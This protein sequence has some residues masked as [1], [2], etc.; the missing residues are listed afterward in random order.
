M[1]E[2][3]GKMAIQEGA[4]YLER[5]MGGKGILLGGVPGVRPARVAILGGGVVGT[6]AAKAAAGLGARVTV[7]DKNA[8]R[9]RYL[10][11]ILPENVDTVSANRRSVREACQEAD[12]LVGAVYSEGAKASR[13]VSEETVKSMRPGSV[14]VDVSIDQGGCV[15]TSHPT[16]HS[17][18]VFTRHG[19]V[20]YC[21]TNIPGAVGM[22]S[23][24][25]LANATLPY[26]LAIAE[27]GIHVAAKKD[28][29]VKHALNI[30]QGRIVHPAVAAAFKGKD[31]PPLKH[32]G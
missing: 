23:T 29:A 32:R 22:T 8:A 6:N 30:V 5:S 24:F 18:P 16:S 7:L 28:P 13:L 3:A 26:V 17:D 25:A 2:V 27:A 12:L 9:L 1:S 19:V 14:I 31:V 4:K 21:V 11:D 15:A 20:H 10:D